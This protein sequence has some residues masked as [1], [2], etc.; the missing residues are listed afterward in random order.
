[1]RFLKGEKWNDKGKAI[2]RW[3][4]KAS[5]LKLMGKRA[6]TAGLP[7]PEGKTKLFGGG[8]KLS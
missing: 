4:R 2:E 7:N 1:M 3:R 8:I 5:G 6:R